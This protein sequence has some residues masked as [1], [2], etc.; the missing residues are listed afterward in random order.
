MDD[1]S[2]D[3]GDIFKEIEKLRKR[4][5]EADLRAKKKKIRDA[6]QRRSDQICREYGIAPKKGVTYH[7]AEFDGGL[8]I[9]K[10]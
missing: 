10:G 3:L 6:I 4:I 1:L 2:F 5:D 8:R 9:R 7:I